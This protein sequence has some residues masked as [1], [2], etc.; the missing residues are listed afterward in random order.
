LQDWATEIIESMQ[1]ICTILDKEEADKPYSAALAE[2]QQLINNPDLT[3]SARMLASMTQVGLPFSR[4]ALNK[5][6]EH[7]RY[8]RLNKL[9][10]AHEQT[11]TEMAELSLAKQKEIEGKEQIPFDDFLKQYFSQK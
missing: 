11:F 1:P 10:A 2:Q 8:F 7:A 4:F 3:A 5:S 6:A 9:D